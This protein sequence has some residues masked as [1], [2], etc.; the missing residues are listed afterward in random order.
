MQASGLA[1][2]DPEGRLAELELELGVVARPAT[3][4]TRQASAR[5]W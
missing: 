2:G 5:E 4:A 3:S 1:G